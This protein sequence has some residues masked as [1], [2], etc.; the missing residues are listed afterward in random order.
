VVIRTESDATPILTL[1]S[2]GLV[3]DGSRVA[4][5]L[6]STGGTELHALE[7]GSGNDR[8]VARFPERRG[9][10]IAWS[11]DGTGLLVSLDEARHPQFFIARVLVAVDIASGT[12]RRS[13]AASARVAHR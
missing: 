9:I 3:S 6:E 4:Y 5:W 11:T 13:T 8:I 10:R 2:Y 1:P 12:T 7:L